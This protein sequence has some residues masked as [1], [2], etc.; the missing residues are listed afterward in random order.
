M[1]RHILI[2]DDEPNLRYG[3]G[4]ALKKAGYKITEAGDGREAL[5]MV[6]GGND[7]DLLLIDIRMPNMSGIELISELKRHDMFTPVVAISGFADSTQVSELM[8]NGCSGFLDKPFEPR[9]LVEMV[10]S[11]LDDSREE[12]CSE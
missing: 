12:I 4:I 1:T 5:S 8:K 2:T 9:E 10:N 11:V 7:F 6:L 3:A